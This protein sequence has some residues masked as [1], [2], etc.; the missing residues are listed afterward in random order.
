MLGIFALSQAFVAFYSFGNKD[1]R[2]F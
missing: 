1:F 2:R